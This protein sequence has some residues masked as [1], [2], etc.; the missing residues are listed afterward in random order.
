[1][2][3]KAL[4]VRMIPTRNA[5]PTPVPSMSARAV[6]APRTPLAPVLF[7]QAPVRAKGGEMLMSPRRARSTVSPAGTT[8]EMPLT[9]M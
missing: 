1:V 9:E 8:A 6:P 7:E 2:D 3:L 4:W 5:M